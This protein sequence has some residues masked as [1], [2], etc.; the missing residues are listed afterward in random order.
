[1][2]A[3]AGLIDE[4]LEDT[5]DGTD[6]EEFSFEEGAAGVPL[7]P[8]RNEMLFDSSSGSDNPLENSLAVSFSPKG[9]RIRFGLRRR[10][11]GGGGGGEGGKPTVDCFWS[12]AFYVNVSCCN[13]IAFLRTFACCRYGVDAR[14]RAGL[15]VSISGMGDTPNYILHSGWLKKRGRRFCV[16]SLLFFYIFFVGLTPCSSQP[17]FCSFQPALP[18]CP[19]RASSRSGC[20]DGSR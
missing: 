14:D 17:P 19:Q 6:N 2:A 5:G 1:M 9:A 12:C 11:G 16:S 18:A 8:D 7:E 10:G 15:D 3:L 20:E 4:F 13:Q